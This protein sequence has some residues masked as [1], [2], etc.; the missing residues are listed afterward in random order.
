MPNNENSCEKYTAYYCWKRQKK[1]TWFN[2]I[3]AIR[4]MEVNDYLPTYTRV[5]SSEIEGSIM[6]SLITFTA[7]TLVSKFFTP[8]VS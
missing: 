4:Y 3:I 2:R 7:I 5:L 8:F 6:M 1:S